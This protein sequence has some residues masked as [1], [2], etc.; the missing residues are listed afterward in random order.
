M[1]LLDRYIASEFWRSFFHALIALLTLFIGVSS[2][3]QGIKKEILPIHALQ[4]TLYEVPEVLV[5]LLPVACLIGAFLSLSAMARRGEIVA[6]F[7][8]SVSLL[9][10]CLVLLCLAAILSCFSLII[11]D[12]VIPPVTKS[13]NHFQRTVIEKKTS[14][15]TNITR[16][17]IWYKSK[18]IIYNLGV[19]HPEGNKIEDLTTYTFNQKFNLVEK[20]NA[21]VARYKDGHWELTDGRITR[22]EGVLATPV[23]TT[24]KEKAFFLK[25]T[26]E[27][28]KSIEKEVQTLRLKYLWQFI[29][30][31][32][33]AGIN[34]APQE[35]LFWS[36]INLA[37]LPLIMTLIAIPICAQHQRKPNSA[38]SLTVCLLLMVAY[39]VF[40]SFSSSLGRSATLSPLISIFL[41]TIV[42]ALLGIAMVVKKEKRISAWPF[43]K[44]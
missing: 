42:F 18:N 39:W 40:Y 26:P 20:V 14:L 21:R 30:H 43:L 15:Q 3:R 2:L 35:M 36:K 23:T 37:L 28:F 8:S 16:S 7:A 6:L 33:S 22:F 9:R 19:F 5:L 17:G 29:L 44:F 38:K 32:R 24:F 27:D 4:Y 12:R 10:I 31:N 41:P 25:E 1:N 11:T 13:K 34:T